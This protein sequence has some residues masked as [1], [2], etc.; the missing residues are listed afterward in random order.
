MMPVYPIPQK[1]KL[2]DQKIER[3]GHVLW[4]KFINTKAGIQ[5]ITHRSMGI[6]TPKNYLFLIRYGKERLRKESILISVS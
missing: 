5:R 3:G 2:V 4:Q 1:L 6:I